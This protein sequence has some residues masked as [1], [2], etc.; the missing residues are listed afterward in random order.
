M[1]NASLGLSDGIAHHSTSINRTSGTAH[2]QLVSAPTH[3]VY[4]LRV[5]RGGGARGGR[6]RNDMAERWP[7]VVEFIAEL[8]HNRLRSR[9]PAERRVLRCLLNEST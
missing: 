5:V 4:A 9:D 6:M 7:L 8:V 1:T 2:E 3:V